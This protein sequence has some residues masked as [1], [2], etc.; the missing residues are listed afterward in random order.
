M[1]LIT[2]IKIKSSFEQKFLLKETLA[3]C[4]E[5]CNYISSIV[6]LSGIDNRIDLQKLL[7]F[8]V[9]EVFGLSAQMTILCI[10]KVANDYH[11]KNANQKRYYSEKSS[12]AFDD[13]VLTIFTNKNEVSIWTLDGRQKVPFLMGDKQKALLD[14]RVG[15][16]DLFFEKGEFFLLVG[17]EQQEEA[18]I[19]PKDFLGVDVG[20]KK[21][22]MDSEGESFSGE[23]VDKV[24]KK[25]ALKR[26]VLQQKNTKNAKRKLCKLRK[27]EKNFKKTQNHKIAKK[28]VL[29]AKGTHC[30]IALEDLKGIRKELTVR[31]K[32]RSWFSSWSFGQLR[33]FIE[34]KAKLHGV[35]VVLV[36]PRNT[37]RTC[38]S[39][40]YIDKKNRKSQ[41][42]F[43]CCS[44]GYFE[45]ADFVGAL[46]IRQKARNSYGKDD[47]RTEKAMS[48][49]LSQSI[50][51]LLPNRHVTGTATQAFAFR[52]E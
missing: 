16:S 30:G 15:Q 29:K 11:N 23:E 39:C 8:E 50:E 17:Y 33:S 18:L 9:K 3:R 5:A 20:M 43:C 1:R 47:I 32:D 46:N 34:Y 31:K 26:K 10:H 27:K 22:A 4:S 44:C 35:T 7:Y 12:I 38:P 28:I 2:K 25:N 42:E 37:S 40:G 14:K 21:L 49:G 51:N 36:N 24:R 6:F 13:R 52:Q 45:N 48:A 19:R 41:A